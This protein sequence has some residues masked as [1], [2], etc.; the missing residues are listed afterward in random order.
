M[1]MYLYYLSPNLVFCRLS[2]FL[3]KST[4]CPKMILGQLIRKWWT[5]TLIGG[6]WGGGH[7]D[8]N[9]VYK[10]KSAK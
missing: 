3:Y 7:R 10:A 2:H 8:A 1:V 6:E 5:E 4:L 9:F